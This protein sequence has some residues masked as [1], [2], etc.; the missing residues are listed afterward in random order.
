M[1]DKSFH[2]ITS[3]PVGTS[4][5]LAFAVVVLASYFATF[6]SSRQTTLFGVGMMAVLGVGYILIGI[7]GYAICV[8]SKNYV[9]R[10][11]YFAVQIPL[12]AGIVYLGKGAGLNAMVLVPLAAHAVVLLPQRWSY[13][14]SMLVVAAY[15]VTVRLFSGAWISVWEG[16]PT[17]L[18]GLIFVVVFTQLAVDEE[19]ARKEIERL[20]GQVEELTVTRER[21]RLA[22]EIH[23]GLGHYL[24]T[25][26]MQVQAAKAVMTTNPTRSQEMLEKAQSLAQEA[27]LDVRQSVSALRL[28]PDE[29]RPLPEMIERL[30]QNG[31]Q[32]EG[33]TVKFELIGQVRMLSP[34]ANWTLYRAAQEGINN[35]RKY[36]QAGEVQVVLDYSLPNEVHLL[37]KDDGVGA[38]T[39]SGGF[40]LLGLR[41]RVHLLNGS[42]QIETSP[43]EG[44]K[45]DVGV[46]G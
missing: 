19:K 42:L 11:V 33:L 26:Y 41:E 2:P 37:V 9:L 20:V 40:G 17:F 29:E 23:D 45:M 31:S 21:N 10:G 4:T 32:Q 18:A 34:Q 1:E 35:A 43:G 14:V 15:L 36:A 12:G 39:L 22:R 6:S 16:L 30:T 46:P 8:R 13:L 5:D 24:T 25:I 44:L 27:L 28:H 3:N 7:Y 38:E